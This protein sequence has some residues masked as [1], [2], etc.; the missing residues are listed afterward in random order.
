MSYFRTNDNVNIYYEINGEGIPIVFI[1]GFSESGHV[2]RIQKRALRKK[3]KIITYDLRGHGKSDIVE[4]GL[5]IKT[6]AKD[7]EEFLNHLNLDKYIVVAWSM[8]A[9]VLLQYIEDFGADR[10]EK[11]IVVD[12]SPKMINDED[13]KLGLYHGHYNI[14]DFNADLKLIREDFERFS[15]KFTEKM[16]S[17][18]NEWELQIAMEKMK[19]NSRE[20]LYNLW[21]SMGEGDYRDTLRKIDIDTLLVFG[22]RSKLYSI[23]TAEYLRDNIEGAKLEVFE[24]NGHLLILENPIRFN[25]VLETFINNM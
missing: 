24:E 23:E 16:S 18:L 10:L 11:I 4:Y 6:L 14:E 13:W 25:K 15:R 1:H 9:S 3:Y 2:F 17:D 22:G 20:V 5:N 7:L 8:G 21:K 12:K 19:K